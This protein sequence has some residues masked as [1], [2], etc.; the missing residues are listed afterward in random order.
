MT[1]KQRMVG[2][3]NSYPSRVSYAKMK[4]FLLRKYKMLS[5]VKKIW[6]KDEGKVCQ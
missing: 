6:F 4:K 2:I 5:T 1:A 3:K